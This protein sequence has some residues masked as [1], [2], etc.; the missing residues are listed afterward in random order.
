MQTRALATLR[1]STPR[2]MLAFLNIQP[3]EGRRVAWMMLYSAAA[4]GGV[5]TVSMATAS[6]PF[7]SELPAA[8]TLFIFIGWGAASV[9][10]S[11]TASLV[12]V[13]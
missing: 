13:A 6:A 4:T 12:S 11:S 2:R 7:L 10:L 1:A 3:A 5:V 8:A 9:A